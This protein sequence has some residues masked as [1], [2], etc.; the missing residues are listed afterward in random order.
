[1]GQDIF[2]GVGV[3]IILPSPDNFLKIKETL[4]RVGIASKK[5]KSYISPVIFC[6]NRADIQF[7]ILRNCSS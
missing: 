6:T 4:T 3:E 1:M 2:R 7:C 5:T